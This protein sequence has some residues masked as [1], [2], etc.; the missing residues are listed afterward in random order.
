M[1]GVTVSRKGLAV[2]QLAETLLWALP[3]PLRR[4][5]TVVR[6]RTLLQFVQFGMV[7]AV[8]FV[9]E[10]AVVYALR[11]TTGIYVAGL[12][13]YAVSATVTWWINRVWTFQKS[14]AG[15]SRHG[16]WMRYALANSPGFLLNRS[17]FFMLVT[18][19]ALCS[20]HPVLAVA[21]GSLAGMF[22]NFT[23]SRVLVFGRS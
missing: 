23:F 2:L 17:V 12:V 18:V 9:A 11:A 4:R 13:A 14:T 15:G 7:G 6:I 22:S 10:T 3:T 8:G 5:F 16:Q 1:I 21:A 19:S 20:A